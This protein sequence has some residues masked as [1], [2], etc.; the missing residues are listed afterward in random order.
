M[1]FRRRRESGQSHGLSSRSLIRPMRLPS[2]SRAMAEP[3]V[4]PAHGR[5]PL[6]LF[7]ESH[8][9][10]CQLAESRLGILDY[11]IEKGI[12]S[13]LR[14]FGTAQHQ[15]RLAALKEGESRRRVEQMDEAENV[16]VEALR[17]LKLLHR[18]CD[19]RDILGCTPDMLDAP[20]CANTCFQETV[21]MANMGVMAGG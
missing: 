16:P 5:D 7:L 20:F 8:P 1:R 4:L 6:R 15:P 12:A 14:A 9:L 2:L 21:S 10:S 3:D 19:L 18:D 17:P 11:I 13:R